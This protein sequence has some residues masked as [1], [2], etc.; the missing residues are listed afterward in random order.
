M[1]GEVTGLIEE[2][3]TVP[4]GSGAGDG[5]AERV[6]GVRSGVLFFGDCPA[7]QSWVCVCD[8]DSI[9]ACGGDGARGATGA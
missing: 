2:L 8:D 3:A 6:D 7:D 5:A 4:D 9:G 1:N